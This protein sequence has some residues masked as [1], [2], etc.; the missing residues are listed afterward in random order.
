MTLNYTLR[1]VGEW[2]ELLKK[3]HRATWTH[4]FQF[5]KA[6]AK[7]KQSST[8]FV[9]IERNSEVIGIV[10]IQEMKLGPIHLVTIH[11]G[12]L[13]IKGHETFANLQEFSTLFNKTYPKRLLRRIRWLPEWH[14]DD[15]EAHYFIEKSP[16]NPTRQSFE[17][18]WLDLSPSLSEIRKALQQKWRNCLHK[19]ER[20]PLT[21]TVDVTGTHLDVFIK[22]YEHFKSRKKFE[23]PNGKFFKE[24]IQTALPYRD[25][26][27]LW[28]K[29]D[30]I[31][32]AGIA[33][34]K[35]GDTAS[36]RL[37]WNTPE[38]RRSNAHYLLLWRAIEALKSY[39]I[40]SLDLGGII[41]DDNDSFNKFK[42]GLSNSRFKTEVLK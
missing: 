36:Y 10:A 37:G 16:F 31:P 8:H 32:V 40:T 19:A 28:A 39:N 35:H 6:V 42:L 9:T 29:Q 3:T 41:P 34:M 14:L 1:T 30:G 26:L 2:R 15:P 33:M 21:V 12:P 17:T 24:E 22:N 13:W 11:R 38:G 5:A 20:S 25:A 18:L 7:V 27:I 23:G 4:T